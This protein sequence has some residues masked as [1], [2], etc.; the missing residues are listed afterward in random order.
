MLIT[1]DAPKLFED[2]GA[3][4]PQN[5]TELPC[6]PLPDPALSLSPRSA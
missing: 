5:L 1:I 3:S 2:K 6:C 4:A